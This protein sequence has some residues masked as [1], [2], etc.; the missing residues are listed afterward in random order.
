MFSSDVL[1]CH[2]I[3]TDEKKTLFHGHI[4]YLLL[5]RGQKIWEFIYNEILNK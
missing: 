4:I 2:N 3:F 5:I 1:F